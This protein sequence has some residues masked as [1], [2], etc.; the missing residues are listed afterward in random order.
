MVRDGRTGQQRMT[1]T[2]GLGDKER[3]VT[4]TRDAAGRELGDERLRGIAPEQAHT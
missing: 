3:T 1:V 2:R 4:R